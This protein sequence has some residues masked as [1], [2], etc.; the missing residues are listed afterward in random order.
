MPAEPA[1][2]SG[3][4][5]VKVDEKQIELEVLSA[6]EAEAHRPGAIANILRGKYD[7][8][9]IVKTLVTLEKDGKAQREG[10]KAWIAKGKAASKAKDS[11]KE[12]EKTKK[13][14]QSSP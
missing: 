14:Q 2:V 11:K 6:I 5:M 7:R 8:N 12:K 4:K 1:S 3:S 10:A 9:T 13:E